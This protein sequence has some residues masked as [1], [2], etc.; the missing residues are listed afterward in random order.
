MAMNIEE[1][2]VLL[3][4]GSEERITQS[5]RDAL[6]DPTLTSVI[7]T[8]PLPIEHVRRIYSVRAD[9]SEPGAVEGFEDLL[10]SLDVENCELVNVHSF[11]A[12]RK[13]FS[14]FTDD[15]ATKLLGILISKQH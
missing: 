5:C 6:N 9:S 2:R 1:L 13:V 8:G 10:K 3:K 14:I 4:L 12:N 11:E 7:S 15:P